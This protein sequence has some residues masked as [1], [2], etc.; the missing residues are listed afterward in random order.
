MKDHIE[1]YNKEKLYGKT[2]KKKEEQITYDAFVPL[3]KARL[4]ERVKPASSASMYQHTQDGVRNG[5]RQ[6]QKASDFLP[7]SNTHNIPDQ[8]DT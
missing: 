8:H 1:V 2:L 4:Q 5:T 7:T 6:H 3:E